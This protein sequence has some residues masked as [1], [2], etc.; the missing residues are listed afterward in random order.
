MTEHP[1]Y[2]SGHLS[3]RDAEIVSLVAEGLTNAEIAPR[4]S[5]SLDTVKHDLSNITV[6]LGCRNRAAIAA[7]WCLNVKAAQ[8]IEAERANGE[9]YRAALEQ[10]R[11]VAKGGVLGFIEDTLG[12]A[13]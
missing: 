12:V 4:L 5:V 10:L 13:A 2:W 11:G 1:R 8:A 3:P 6:R 7:W 9:R